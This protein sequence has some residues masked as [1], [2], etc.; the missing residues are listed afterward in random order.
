[1][2]RYYII[3]ALTV[4][5][6]SVSQ[7]LMKKGAMESGFLR[8]YFNVYTLS[9]YFLLFC[10]TLLNLFVLRGVALK[11][12]VVFLPFNYILVLAAAMI[13][14]GE[15]I[16]YRQYIGSGIVIAGVIIYNL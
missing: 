1:M 2:H 11:M 4:V 7:V 12:M 10:V 3:L 6:T 16:S 5:M 14:F 9:G 13:V 8:L 15:K